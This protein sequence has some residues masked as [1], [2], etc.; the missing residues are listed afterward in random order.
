MLTRCNHCRS[1]NVADHREDPKVQVCLDCNDYQYKVSLWYVNAYRVTLGYG[2]PEEGGWWYSIHE[3]IASIPVQ[4][5]GEQELAEAHLHVM[6]P[7]PGNKSSVAADAHDVI[8]CVE[9]GVAEES[10]KERPRYE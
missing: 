5:V 8:V 2:G 7:N 6:F 10:P 1:Y 3:P 9:E 4:S